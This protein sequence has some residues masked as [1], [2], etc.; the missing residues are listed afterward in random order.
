MWDSGGPKTHSM[1]RMTT[2]TLGFITGKGVCFCRK[3][4]GL[5]PASSRAKT[6]VMK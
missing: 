2:V 5:K 1:T 4:G 6:Q 3:L